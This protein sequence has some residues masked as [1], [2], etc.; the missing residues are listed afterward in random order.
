MRLHLL[1]AIL[2][3]HQNKVDEAKS[4]FKK[5]EEELNGLKVDDNHL[6]HLMEIGESGKNFF[7]FFWALK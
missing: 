4:L 6:S 2:L 1:Q 3:Y 5:A 7:G